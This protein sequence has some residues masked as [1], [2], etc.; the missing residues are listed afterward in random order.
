MKTKLILI[1]AY[2]FIYSLSWASQID[3]ISTTEA[4]PKAEIIIEARLDSQKNEYVEKFDDE[5][6]DRKV[7]YYSI[8]DI[9]IIKGIQ[10]FYKNQIFYCLSPFPEFRRDAKGNKISFRVSAKIDGTGNEFILGNDK[11]YIFFI[12]TAEDDKL[13]VLRV[14]ESTTEIMNKIINCL[15]R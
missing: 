9:K 3:P 13:Q 5:Y 2:Q 12:K 8:S 11:R 4:I 10:N 6:I 14:E 1:L 7:I 15:T